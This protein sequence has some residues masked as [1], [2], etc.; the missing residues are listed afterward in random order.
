MPAAAASK[1]GWPVGLTAQ[2]GDAEGFAALPP[3]PPPPER[4]GLG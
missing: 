1:S 2:K 3:A 4:A